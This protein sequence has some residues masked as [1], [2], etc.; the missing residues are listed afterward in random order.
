MASG[1]NSYLIFKYA[2]LRLFMT[3]FDISFDIVLNVSDL[4]LVLASFSD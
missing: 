3:V 2:V 4:N 1:K